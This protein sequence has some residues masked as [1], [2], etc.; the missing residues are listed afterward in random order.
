MTRVLVTGFEPFDGSPVNASWEAVQLLAERWDGDAELVVRELPIAFG[1]AGRRIAAHVASH[2][3][4]AVVATGVAAGTRDLGVERIAV[5]HL[6]EADI[7]RNPLVMQILRAYEED[8]PRKR[9]E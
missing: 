9:K 1:A 8:R 6:D 5:I 7:V 4:D 2:T 3:P